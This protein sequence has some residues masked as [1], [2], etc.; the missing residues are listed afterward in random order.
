MIATQARQLPGRL[1]DVEHL[2]ELLSEPTP[3][4][5]ETIARLEGDILFLGVGGKMGPTMARMARRAADEV[6]VPRRVMGVSR[7]SSSDL[8]DRLRQN[9]IETI[10]CDMLDPAQLEKLPDAPNVVFMAGMKFGA[11]GQEA[12]TWAMN[13]HLPALVANRFRHSRIV[14]FS[15]GNVYGLSPVALCG[16]RE[17]DPPQPV[18]EYAQSCVGRE[19]MFEH[20]SRTLGIPTA[21][22]RLNYA[23]EMRYGV[24]VDIAL[25]VVAGEPIDLAMGYLN[26][27]WQGDANA[28]ALQAFSHVASPPFVLNLAGPETLSVRRIAGEFARLLSKSVSFHGA[29][30]PDALLSNGQQGHYLFGYPRISVQQMLHWIADWVSHGGAS[31][32]KPTHFESRDGKF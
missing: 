3:G 11:T 12:L 31:H 29:E 4:V 1:R 16:S 21:L 15:T 7:F 18:G 19:R 32:G 8:E 27:I 25:R 28:M 13:C 24:L 5:I 2:E 9:G 14:A 26:A 10:R 17:T 30:S 22:L 20:F 6:G 23:T